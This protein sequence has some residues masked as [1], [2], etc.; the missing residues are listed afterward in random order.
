[1]VAITCGRMKMAAIA[2][3][4]KAIMVDVSVDSIAEVSKLLTF[5]TNFFCLFSLSLES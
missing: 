4:A 2:M 5:S 3:T 1:M